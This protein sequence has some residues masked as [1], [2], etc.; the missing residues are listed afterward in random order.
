MLRQ[1]PTNYIRNIYKKQFVSE[2]WLVAKRVFGA[3]NLQLM[4][5]EN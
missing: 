4:N 5:L 3:S 2:E 1:R